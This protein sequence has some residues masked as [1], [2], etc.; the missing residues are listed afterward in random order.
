MKDPHYRKILEGLGGALDPQVFEACAVDL[1]RGV[2]PGLVPVHGGQDYGMD[3]AIA[4]GEGE[5]YPLVVTTAEDVIRNLT[6]N[7]Y[8][9]VEGNGRR[10]RV[11]VAT[12]RPLTARRRKNLEERAREKGFTLVQIHDRWDIASRLYRDSRWT[13]ELLGLT[14]RAFGAFGD[15]LRR[16]G[17]SGRT[18]S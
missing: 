15:S 4:D 18:W 6:K 8:S 16:I 1:L 13:H 12:S 9:Y 17:R 5:P 3:G 10:R 14:G 11:V 7:L 2:Y